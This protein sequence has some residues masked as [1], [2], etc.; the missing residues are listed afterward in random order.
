[1]PID[2]SLCPSEPGSLPAC[3]E[4]EDG[5]LCRSNG[6]CGTDA[7]LNN[8][9]GSAVYLREHGQCPPKGSVSGYKE[10]RNCTVRPRCGIGS[11]DDFWCTSSDGAACG[12]NFTNGWSDC[13]RLCADGNQTRHFVLLAD[14]L[15]ANFTNEEFVTK[16]CFT[17]VGTT[18][19]RPCVDYNATCEA[20]IKCDDFYSLW[21]ECDRFCDGGSEYRTYEVPVV[22]GFAAL[23]YHM[24]VCRSDYAKTVLGKTCDQ[25]PNTFA[26]MP[27]VVYRFA[28]AL[29]VVVGVAMLGTQTML[30]LLS[31]A[32]VQ[33][34][35]GAAITTALISLA[36]GANVPKSAM[37]GWKFGRFKCLPK[38]T[39]RCACENTFPMCHVLQGISNIMCC[40]CS[41][42]KGTT[43][44]F[45]KGLTAI[46]RMVDHTHNPVV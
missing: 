2:A 43:R 36:I 22:E 23:R 16:Q 13:N 18:E 29:H 8:C 45:A 14:D 27:S 32:A 4:V 19:N 3:T 31:N 24:E 12:S 38:S 46:C 11:C 5:E 26:L 34:G 25:T 39:Q 42:R 41:F 15:Y 21:T 1:M 28:F 10:A 6:E 40:F 30:F 9:N 7:A 17:P 35:L 37:A 44:K 33:V 20:D